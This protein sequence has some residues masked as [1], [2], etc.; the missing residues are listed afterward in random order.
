MRH[1]RTVAVSVVVGSL[2]A[3]AAVVAS[4]VPA[5]AG[6]DPGSAVCAQ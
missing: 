6:S 1:A 4:E 2:A 5:F 3:A